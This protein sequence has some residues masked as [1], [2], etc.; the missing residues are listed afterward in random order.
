MKA[1]RLGEEKIAHLNVES[2]EQVRKRFSSVGW[3]RPALISAVCPLRDQL[4]SRAEKR[5]AQLEKQDSLGVLHIPQINIAFLELQPS[6]SANHP[7]L[8]PST[9]PSNDH[10][11]LT[12]S[13]PSHPYQTP[14]AK[15]SH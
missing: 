13:P 10:N 3:N 8:E 5:K 11:Q 4:L 15:T 6:G 1:S 14:W 7:P 2:F 12:Q 9:S